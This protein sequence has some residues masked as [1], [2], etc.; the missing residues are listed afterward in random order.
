MPRDCPLLD[1][2]NCTISTCPMTCAHIQYL[3]TIPGNAVYAAVLGLLLIVQTGLGIRFKTWGFMVG[4]ICGLVLEVVGYAG[5]IMLHNNPFDFNNFIIYL[6]PLTIGPAF[7]AGSI[8]LCLS[9]IVIVYGQHISRFSPRTYSIVFMS[10][11]F[12]SLVLQGTGGG[13]AATANGVAGSNAGRNIMLAGLV[14]QVF[15]LLV[16][17]GLWLEFIFR[18]SKTDNHH[19]DMRFIDLRA[20][21]RFLWFQCALWLAVV[22]IF[23]RSVYRVA[24]LQQGFSGSIAND[25]PLFMVFEGPMI[26]I[27]VGVLTIFHPGI[28]FDGK[29]TDAVWSLRGRPKSAGSTPSVD[30]TEM[31]SQK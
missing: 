28:S 30:E 18:L 5:R 14:F 29:W 9:R 10:C 25:E 2:T 3:P 13:I 31:L 23:M 15:S 8:Y 26:I 16:F 27:A 17:M 11:D 4:M 21:K 7:L 1:T 6:V 20:S 22:L 24:E 19:K 12:F